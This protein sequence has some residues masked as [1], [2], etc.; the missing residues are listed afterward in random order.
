[1]VLAVKADTA[2]DWLV[3]L[4]RG[5]GSPLTRVA[6]VQLEEVIAAVEYLT[7]Y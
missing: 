6:E 5:V 2:N 7:S 3:P 4:V 1:M